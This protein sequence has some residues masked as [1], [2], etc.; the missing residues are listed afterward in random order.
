MREDMAKVI[1][2]RPR[3]RGDAARKGRRQDWD[4]M[5]SHEGM[6]RPH[7]LSGDPKELNEHLGPLRR[8]LE[9]Q[10]GRPWDKVYSEK[11][12]SS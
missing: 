12:L 3:R 8:Y 4:Q 7:I 6:R 9:R 11:N 10:V 2:E 1:V 5:P